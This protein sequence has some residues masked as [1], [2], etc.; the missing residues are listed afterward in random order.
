MKKTLLT[1]GGAINLLLFFFH[2]RMIFEIQGTFIDSGA[3]SLLHVFNF[4]S[5]LAVYYF[6]YISF[7]Y[8]ESL[9]T[10]KLGRSLVTLIALMYLARII[11]QPIFLGFWWPIITI[12][13][14]TFFLYLAVLLPI[15]LKEQ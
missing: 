8:Q 4:T 5:A 13:G 6:A 2:I 14:V 11:L 1:L 9:I 7:F 15:G 3:R 10:T 12:C